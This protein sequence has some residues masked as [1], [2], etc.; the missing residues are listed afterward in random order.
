MKWIK[1]IFLLTFLTS[2]WSER[3]VHRLI[4]QQ[5]SHYW[6]GFEN[7]ISYRLKIDTSNEIWFTAHLTINE[8][9]TLILRG[10]EKGNNHPTQVVKIDN[11][12]TTRIG[13]FF[14]WT[15]GWEAD[16]VEV[17]NDWE[18]IPKLPKSIMMMK[19]EINPVATKTISNSL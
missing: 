13:S 11:G 10:F 19:K 1:V 17:V 16:T 4:D 2:C 3:Q 12:D 9:D 15:R 5:D 18:T 8:N 6:Q 14:I 7:N